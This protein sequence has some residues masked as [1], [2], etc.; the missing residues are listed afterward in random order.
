MIPNK[1]ISRSDFLYKITYQRLARGGEASI[2]ETDNPYSLYKFFTLSD[3][4]KPMSKNKLEKLSRLYE[5]TPQHAIKPI[6][7]ISLNDV[8]IGYEMETDPDLKT[9]MPCQ[10]YPEELKYF[11]TKSK[12]ILEYFQTL[13]IIYGDIDP[14]NILFDRNTGEIK[15]CDMDNISLDNLPM[16]LIPSEVEFYETVRPLD[17]GIHPFAHNKMTLRALDI[18][19]YWASKKQLSKH[20]TRPAIKIVESMQ[21]PSN[22]NNKYLVQYFKK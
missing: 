5:L 17:F 21:D 16:D 1:E 14:R 22:F 9:Y 12:D 10:L 20:F 3:K 7:T 15:F 2:C 19:T 8:I 18:D 6:S 11:L 13:N 4:V